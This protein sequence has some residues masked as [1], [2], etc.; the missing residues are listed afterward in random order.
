MMGRILVI[1]PN[2]FM[3]RKASSTLVF[4][5]VLLL[6]YAFPQAA[7]TEP[8]PAQHALALAKNG[9]CKEALPL[10]KKSVAP[11]TPKAAHRDAAMAGV[12]CA[13]FADQPDSA[14]EFLR[15]LNREFPADPDVLYLSVHTY[16][17][18]SSRAASELA[19]KAGNSYQAHELNAEAL[20]IQGKW[21]DAE[22][23]YRTILEKYPNVPGIHFRIGRLLLSVP[24]PPPDNAE[25][26]KQE[27]VEELK[28]DPTNPGAEY[29]LGE[30]ARQANSYDEAVEHFTK[31][32]KLDHL[33]RRCISQ[34][35][36][37]AGHREEVRRSRPLARSRREAST[38]QSVRALQPRYGVQP[39][40]TQSR[41]RPRICHS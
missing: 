27:F 20:E 11:G 7:K 37:Y 41:C 10:L 18:L 38:C 14:L 5:T 16:S 26:A 40:R 34:P 35:R 22:K 30:L 24:N 6:S 39:R 4:V 17:D 12:R 28:I 21:Q 13:M 23:E 31:A 32:T 25:K 9:H 36:G 2:F 3:L 29:V 19:G 1:L 33:L 8:D 15:V